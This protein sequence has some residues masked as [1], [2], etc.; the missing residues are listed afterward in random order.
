MIIDLPVRKSPRAPWH[1][2]DGAEYFVTI[3]TCDRVHYFGEVQDGRIQLMAIGEYLKE[4]IESVQK[5]YS[6]AEIPLYV[7]MPNH[8]HMVVIMDH[9][10]VGTQF[11]AS[12]NDVFDMDDIEN[13]GTQFIASVDKR[14]SLKLISN[15]VNPIS[16][17]MNRVPTGG[18]TGSENPLV[19]QSLGTVVRGLKARVTHFAHK[20]DIP[21][22]WQSRYHDHI[23]RNRN[24]MNR[25]AEYIE[26]NPLIWEL[27]C[28]YDNE[29]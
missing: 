9:R 13:V 19:N 25:I 12:A 15:N 22:A 8:V 14:Q 2:Y 17:A 4:Q 18:V 20:N 23:V 7:I 28:F 24:E 6:Y 1:H 5:Y 21:F 26:Q 11:I 29:N 27:D 16:D 3:C 10:I